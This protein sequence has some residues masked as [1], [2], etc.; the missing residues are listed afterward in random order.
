ME[1]AA[2]TGERLELQWADE[3]SERAY[4]GRIQVREV[5]DEASG[6]YLVGVDGEGAAV[7][8]RVDLI[9]NLPTPVK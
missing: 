3:T 9:R 2:L 7:R 4:L 1:I 5:L 6:C 8:I